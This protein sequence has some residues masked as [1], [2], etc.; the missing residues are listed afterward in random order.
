M[1]TTVL[2]VIFSVFFVSVL[3]A[4]KPLWNMNVNYFFDNTEYAKSSIT[5]DQTMTGVHFTPEIGLAFDSVHSFFAGGDFLKV[6]GSDKFVDYIEPIAYYRY[7]TPKSTFYAG[8]FPRSELFSNYSDLFFQDSVAYFKPTVQGIFWQAGT[9]N[10]FFNLWLDWTGHQTA[11]VRETFFVGASAHHQFGLMFLDFQ[12]YMFHFADTRPM[13]PTYSVCDNILAHLSVG[14][15]FSNQ[16]GID[17]LL[18]AAGVLAGGER[19]RSV[20]NGSYFPIGA[21]IRL[22][23]EYKGFGT[24][25]MLY[26]G[27]RRD[28]FYNNYSNALYWNNPFL[29]A[30]FYFQS[31]WYLDVI[32]S[33]SVNGK[34][35]MN[36]HFSEGKMMYEQ[37][38]TLRAMLNNSA[39]PSLKSKP[40]FM[41]NWFK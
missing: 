5:K 8:V 12:S 35:S 30:G 24:Q 36:L 14:V 4:Q 22:N 6:A 41:T 16:T 7:H 21:V 9:N 19:D 31:K 17:T 26:W 18:F 29:R 33:Q 28:V 37:V 10:S 3:C 27:D 20:V 1:K 2:T 25:N 40:T 38:F 11:T 34:L 13:N 39:K 15:D 32:R 23:A